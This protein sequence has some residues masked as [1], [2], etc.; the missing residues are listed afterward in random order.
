MS[1]LSF[2]SPVCPGTP[3]PECSPIFP[4]LSR[5]VQQTATSF[6]SSQMQPS[7]PS[8]PFT[9]LNHPIQQF[10]HPSNL[11]YNQLYTE[12][13]TSFSTR[14]SCRPVT[15]CFSAPITEIS[16]NTTTIGN[17]EL[18]IAQDV[19]WEIKNTSQNNTGS[20][21]WKMTRRIFK[22]EEL[23]GKNFYGRKGKPGLSP[24]RRN[25]IEHAILDTYGSNSALTQAVTAINT[26]IR[27]LH[28]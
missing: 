11:I 7:R 10:S 5:R 17:N 9:I 23:H 27:N 26:G 16:S 19:Q 25:A 22:R 28:R 1:P 24:R 8:Q 15:E 6:H 20:F 13:A 21:G 12:P 3:S 4:E 2:P 14:T 18:R